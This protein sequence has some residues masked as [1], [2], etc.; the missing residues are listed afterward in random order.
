[1]ALWLA[2]SSSS[3]WPKALSLRAIDIKFYT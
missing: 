1:V 3:R 2:R